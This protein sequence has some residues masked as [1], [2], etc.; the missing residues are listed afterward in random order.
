MKKR[1]Y[2]LTPTINHA[3]LYR[4]RHHLHHNSG[5]GLLESGMVG[6]KD[7]VNIMVKNAVDVIIGGLSYWL[8]GYAFSFGDSDVAKNGFNGWG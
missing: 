2:L 8:F 7:E 4:H 3:P 6:K 1:P 5:F